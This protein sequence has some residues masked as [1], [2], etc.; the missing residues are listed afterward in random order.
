MYFRPT[1]ALD[2]EIRTWSSYSASRLR[3]ACSDVVSCHADQT[4]FPIL[5]SLRLVNHDG[6]RDYEGLLHSL[7]SCPRLHTLDLRGRFSW[8]GFGC[9]GLSHLTELKVHTFAGK[10]VADLLCRL[11]SLQKCEISNIAID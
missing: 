3:S 7:S 1:A 6:E 5:E 9:I 10:S 2:D 11:P 4:H 8:S